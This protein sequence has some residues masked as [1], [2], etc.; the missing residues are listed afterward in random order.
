MRSRLPP[1]S[2]DKD[3]KFQTWVA[4]AFI[5]V[6]VLA[7]FW[8]LTLM[9]G[10][11]ITDDI[12]ASD[13]MN[14]NFPY[15]FSL[16]DA[17][18]SGHLPLWMREIYGGFPLLA[19]ADAGICYPFNLLLFGLFSP[20]VALNLT[21]LLTLITAGVGM[22]L[23]A[24]EL[25]SNHLASIVAGIAF[26]FSGYLVSHLK[27]PSLANA[28]CWLPL[29]LMLLERAAR[30][31]HYR[32]LLW[33]GVVFG[34]QQL[35]GNAQTAYYSGVLYLFYFPLRFFNSQRDVRDGSRKPSLSSSV[36]NLFK[37]RLTWSFAGVLVLGSLLAAIQLIPTYEMVSLSQ[38]SGGVT[39]QYAS[40]YAYD[41]KDFWSFFYPYVNGDIGNL[42][43]SGKGVFWED[44]GYVGA[45]TLFLAV[46]AALRWWRNWH[47]RFFSVVAVIS[48]LLVLGPATP[49]YRFVFDYVP[50]MSYFRFPTR[51]LFITDGSLAVLAALGLT[52]FAQQ[53]LGRAPSS[54]APSLWRR[55]GSLAV[56][57]ILLLL[58]VA[59]LL[60]FQL[61]QNPIVDP[62]RWMAPPKTVR[63]LQQDPSL[64][65][66]F[67]V[68]GNQSHRRAFA[69]ARGWEGDLQP[70]LDQREFLQPSS[71]VLYGISSPNGY[72]NLTPNYL[73][74]IWGDQNRA[75]IITQT[76]STQGDSFQPT[77]VFWKLMR[78]YNVKYLTSFWPFTVAPNL[79]P[80]GIY[81]G[82]YLYQNDDFLP[83]AYLVADVLPVA[84][85]NIALRVLASDA[86]APERSVMLD[87]VPPNYR[88]GDGAAGSVEVVRYTTNEAEMKV[89]AS[90]DAI[91]VF[92]DSYYPGWIAEIDGSPTAIYRANVTQRAVVVPAGEHQVRFRF[93]PASV[94]AGFLV[95]SASLL[96]FLGCFL[97][98]PFRRKRASGTT[99]ALLGARADA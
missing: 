78:M 23:Y 55:R 13:L 38:R 16:G 95:S 2:I 81:S 26:G 85:D 76:A 10:L 67:S 32:L 90:R 56:Q 27:H 70:F 19:R 47:V 44:Y 14:E 83:R 74:D 12:F 28:A 9:K 20:Y 99:S 88:P 93:R 15:R 61:R 84:D 30:R 77:P 91:L 33:F 57:V 75:G 79:R 40:S 80:L 59:D 66:I 65:R 89:Q 68:G 82:A 97:I 43:Y 71:N 36:L 69:Q 22:Y 37:N 51:L 58:V 42:T 87:A 96:V 25:G 35:S 72:A 49:V 73:V 60:H 5:V 4:V 54:D 8:K 11:L 52:R 1:T 24:R 18:K 41:P 46:F 39:F 31:N 45:V 7:A 53:F 6:V 62:S 21:I 64:F 48:Y 29:A 98:P 94:L 63:I 50:G 86:F 92:S 17:L 3:A 34:L